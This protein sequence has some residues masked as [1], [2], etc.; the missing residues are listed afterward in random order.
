M[1]DNWPITKVHQ[2]SLKC[3]ERA[4]PKRKINGLKRGFKIAIEKKFDC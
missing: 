4:D 1:A 2:L 3:G